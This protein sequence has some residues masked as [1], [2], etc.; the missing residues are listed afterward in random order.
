V[1]SESKPET[2]ERDMGGC[3]VSEVVCVCYF[4]NPKAALE[5]V[6]I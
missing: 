3:V 1:W 6:T 4:S 2:T 5:Y